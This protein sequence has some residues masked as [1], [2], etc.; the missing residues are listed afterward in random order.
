VNG[1]AVCERQAVRERPG[2]LGLPQKFAGGRP[3][4]GVERAGGRFRNTPTGSG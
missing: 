3:V 2:G 4:F 1:K